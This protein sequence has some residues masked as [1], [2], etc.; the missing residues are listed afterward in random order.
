MKL[1]V[2][3][4]WIFV[5]HDSSLKCVYENNLLSCLFW[6]VTDRT[7]PLP[8]KVSEVAQM[9]GGL[10][11]HSYVNVYPISDSSEAV[12]HLMLSV[13]P[14]PSPHDGSKVQMLPQGSHHIFATF[15]FLELRRVSSCQ[16]IPQR[17][18]MMKHRFWARAPQT[19]KDASWLSG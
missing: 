5:K 14:R 10:R 18:P 12:G 9:N 8:L 19:S 4:S 11:Q 13:E 3:S 16:E 17:K 6:V 7:M 1:T 2:C 15:W